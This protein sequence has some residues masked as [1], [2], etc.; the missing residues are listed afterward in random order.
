VSRRAI[1]DGFGR[2]YRRAV[3]ARI[4]TMRALTLAWVL[5]DEVY[6]HGALT[7]QLGY[8]LLR[9]ETGLSGWQLAAARDDLVTARLLLVHSSGEGR[10][11]RTEWT[12]R[13]NEKVRRWARVNALVRD[14]N[15]DHAQRHEQPRRHLVRRVLERREQDEDLH[16]RTERQR[17]RHRQ[18]AVRPAPLDDMQAPT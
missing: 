15:D 18:R 4:T 3:F 12:L 1:P 17:L 13:W 8:R 16:V 2:A 7:V 10:K 11:A 9:D 6:V 14:G 5:V